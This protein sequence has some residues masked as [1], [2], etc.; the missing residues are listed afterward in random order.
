MNLGKDMGRCHRDW[1]GSYRI[2]GLRRKV[3]PEVAIPLGLRGVGEAGRPESGGTGNWGLKT[4]RK[5]VTT[6][7]TGDDDIK[8]VVTFVTN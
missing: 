1:A 8:S 2:T 3:V 5:R 7:T 6:V 4:Q